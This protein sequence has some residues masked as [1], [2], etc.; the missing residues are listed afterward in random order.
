V[1]VPK[2][3]HQ[4]LGVVRGHGTFS[5]RSPRRAHVGGERGPLHESRCG[6]LNGLV[7]KRIGLLLTAQA[8]SPRKAL[9][10]VKRR[11]SR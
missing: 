11:L 5:F 9:N 1:P 6:A 7:K 10:A 3:R 2:K 4:V 8:V